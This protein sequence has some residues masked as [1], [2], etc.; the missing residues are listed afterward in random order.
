[1]IQTLKDKEETA[2][3]FGS[4]ATIRAILE[5][6]MSRVSS[7]KS[8]CCIIHHFTMYDGN[9]EKVRFGKLFTD[10]YCFFYCKRNQHFD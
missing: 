7:I 6:C 2:Q 10:V 3:W 5:A 1:M 4:P 9:L 8:Q